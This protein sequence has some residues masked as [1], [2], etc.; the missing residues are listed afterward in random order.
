MPPPQLLCRGLLCKFATLSLERIQ[1]TACTGVAFSDFSQLKKAHCCCMLQH[2]GVG[3]KHLTNCS[4]RFTPI[5]L[6]GACVSTPQA[7]I[8]FAAR[9]GGWCKGGRVLSAV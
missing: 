9:A 8:K 7:V 5:F 6:V 2:V 1:G 4:G 3:H